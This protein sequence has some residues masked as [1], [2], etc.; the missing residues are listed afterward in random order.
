MFLN[1]DLSNSGMNGANL[2]LL[3]L[4]VEGSNVPAPNNSL[5]NGNY[6]SFSTSSS[7]ILSQGI[8]KCSEIF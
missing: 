8:D 5:L 6:Q 4:P 7:P 1:L 3:P 2:V